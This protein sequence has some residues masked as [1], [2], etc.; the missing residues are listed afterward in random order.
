MIEDILY[1]I[2]TLLLHHP[3]LLRVMHVLF[4]VKY[5][6]LTGLMGVFV[7]LAYAEDYK[8]SEEKRQTAESK[9][10]GRFLA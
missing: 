7:F 1:S 9:S 2:N 8:R 4:W 10:A 3:H 5:W 6:I